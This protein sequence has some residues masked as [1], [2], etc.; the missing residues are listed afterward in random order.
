MVQSAYRPVGGPWGAPLALSTPAGRVAAPQVAA[1]GR[2]VV[3]TWV[4]YDG[5]D[6]ITQVADRDSKTGA[7][8][9]PRSLSPTGRDAQVPEIAVDAHGDTVVVW[10]DVGSTNWTIKAAYRDAGGTWGETSVLEGP[11]LGT[12]VPAVVIDS[13]GSPTAVWAASSGTGWAVHS[14]SRTSSGAWSKP[15]VVS[16]LDATGS[17]APQ[18]ALAGNGDVTA[19]WSRAVAATTLLEWATRSAS[20]GTWSTPKEL[21]PG[22]TGVEPQIAANARGDGVIL[23]TDSGATGFVLKASARRPGKA[24]GKATVLASAASGILSPRI[25]VDGEGGGVA[26]WSHPTGGATRV[27]A[28]SLRAGTTRWA[29]A[30]DLSS[31]LGDAVTPQVAVRFGRRRG[32][33]L[34]MV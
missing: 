20:A 30:R 11:E 2:T 19:V 5:K 12:S 3:A 21:F 10:T 34:G 29:A 28:T 13:A 7:W 23:W 17:I 32:D 31:P 8:S 26:V 24:W 16:G 14:S 15:V 4:R 6:L 22:A 27:E 33:R 1:A 18:L 9:T 25:A